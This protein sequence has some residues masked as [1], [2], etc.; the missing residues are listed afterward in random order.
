MYLVPDFL[1][2]GNALDPAHYIEDEL[3]EMFHKDELDYYIHPR[4]C[5]TREQEK[6]N[7]LFFAKKNRGKKA[8]QVA[9]SKI[10][11]L[12]NEDDDLPTILATDVSQLHLLDYAFKRQGICFELSGF[13]SVQ[14]H[15]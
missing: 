7:R 13:M 5:V 12:S 11:G 8:S 6:D 1:H 4:E 14:C 15:A 2:P 3:L 10:L 9:L